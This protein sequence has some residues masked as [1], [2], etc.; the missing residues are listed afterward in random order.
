M[1]VGERPL[2][3]VKLPTCTCCRSSTTVNDPGLL[4]LALSNLIGN[5]WKFTRN[6]EVAEIEVGRQMIDGE[7]AYFVRDNGAGFNMNHADRLFEPFA[8][9]HRQEEF[10]GTGIGLSLVRKIVERHQ[11][12]MWSRAVEG[13]GAT[14]FFT[15]GADSRATVFNPALDRSLAIP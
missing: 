7:P 8:R 2:K 10:E 4:R 11:G 14:F 9:L 13:S 3:G 1:A 15:L 6:I 5:A 12:R